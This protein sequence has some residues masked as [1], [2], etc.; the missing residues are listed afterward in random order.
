MAYKLTYV[1]GNA[2]FSQ[3]SLPGDAYGDGIQQPVTIYE[4]YCSQTFN[5]NIKV[6][7]DELQENL[8]QTIPFD[9]KVSSFA[10]SYTDQ[11]GQSYTAG[12]E[13]GLTSNVVLTPI[14][15]ND[16]EL[17]TKE[18]D[19]SKLSI[20]IKPGYTFSGWSALSGEEIVNDKLILADNPVYTEDRVI[21][22]NWTPNLITV[23]VEHSFQSFDDPSTY[24]SDPNLTT[25][26]SGYADEYCVVPV[27]NVYGF[28]SPEQDEIYLGDYAESTQPLYVY[29][30]DREQ[31]TLTIRQTEGLSIT[32]TYDDKT[33]SNASSITAPY[34][35]VVRLNPVAL[36]GYEFL[37][38]SDY[39]DPGEGQIFEPG[40]LSVTL[41]ENL[42]SP[43][44]ICVEMV[45]PEPEEP[46]KPN[47]NVYVG[48]ELKENKGCLVN[49]GKSWKNILKVYVL[50]DKQWKTK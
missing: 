37:G 30:Y 31:Y 49:I 21:Y 14:W 15:N 4:S 3:V 24:V 18:V 40:A 1:A 10:H 50:K 28:I 25:T 11:N 6:H 34:E 46:S 8:I 44:P 29:C 47:I 9:M 20:P 19:L 33:V 35:T 38:W 7:L 39:P 23:Q 43:Y 16:Y 12:D 42:T 41:T 13:V 32:A 22:A 36:E 17:D 45:P 26:I 2:P 27:K 48:N 5:L